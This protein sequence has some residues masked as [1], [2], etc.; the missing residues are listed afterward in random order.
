[1]CK[2]WVDYPGKRNLYR[3][4]IQSIDALSTRKGLTGIDVFHQQN[5]MF[6]VGASSNAKCCQF[7]L[8]KSSSNLANYCPQFPSSRK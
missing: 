3:I 8:L 2:D 4:E 5:I 6:P 1:M 7:L